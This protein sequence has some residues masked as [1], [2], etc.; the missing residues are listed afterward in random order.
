LCGSDLRG[1]DPSFIGIALLAPNAV[2]IAGA[3]LMMVALELQT[4]LIEEPYLTSVHGEQHTVYADRVGSLPPRD[5]PPAAQQH[6][7]KNLEA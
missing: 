5:R 2:T 7:D 3:I 4:R 1:D 6:A